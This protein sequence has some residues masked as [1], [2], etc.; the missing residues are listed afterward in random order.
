MNTTFAKE[1]H[2][3]HQTASGAMYTVD[4]WT[5]EPST[6]SQTIYLQAGLHGIEITGIPVLFEMMRIIE[7]YQP[8][9]K[10]IVVPCSNPMGLDSQIMGVQTGYNNIHT[11]QQNCYNWNRISHL[12]HTPSIEGN[13][14]RFLLELS[15][16]SEI[17]VDLHTAGMEASP[18]IYSHQSQIE[19]AKQFGIPNIIAWEDVSTSFSDTCYARGQRAF[20][21]ELSQ[22]R[23]VTPR[24]I[25]RSL[26]YLKNYFGW[27]TLKAETRVWNQH[28]ALVRW[29]APAGGILSWSVKAGEY[30]Q[31]GEIA[32]K[33]YT[34]Q[35]ILPLIVPQSGL[36][37]LKNPIHAPHQH[38]E[39]GKLLIES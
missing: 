4:V 12:S 22:S 32:G 25:E 2:E 16:T 28:N 24:L 6:Y 7:E 26:N 37:L 21:L 19:E 36:F 3:L 13:W 39:I 14:I 11:N 8:T 17:I 1:T 9:H 30:L 27:H 38:Q 31:Q 15:Q 33:L 35:S 29:L 10:I 23:Q 34:K 20:T 18:H 5:Y